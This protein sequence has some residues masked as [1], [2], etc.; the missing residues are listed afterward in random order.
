M[1]VLIV[2]GLHLDHWHASF[3]S[4]L[5]ALIIAGDLSN[6]PKVRWPVFLDEI[7]QLL[8]RNHSVGTACL[9]SG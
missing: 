2:A 4:S 3:W 5:D 6:N 8:P 7:R 9:L 1:S